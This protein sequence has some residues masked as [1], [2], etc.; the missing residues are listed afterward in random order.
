M[1]ESIPPAG[2]GEMRADFP[3]AGLDA[4][5]NLPDTSGDR[6]RLGQRRRRAGNILI[7]DIT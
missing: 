7:C 4:G 1:P 6:W 5:P 3:V 2:R